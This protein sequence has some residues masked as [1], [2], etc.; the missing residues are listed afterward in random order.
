MSARLLE[1]S[2][3]SPSLGPAVVALGV[4][5]G[6]H[7][8]HAALVRDAVSIA[9]VEGIASVV[10]TFDRDPDRVVDPD[11]AAPQLLELDD[12]FDE[13]A[14]L[15]PDTVLVVPFD[16]GIAVMTPDAFLSDVLSRALDPVTVVV[17]HDFRFGRGASGDVAAL[18]RFGARAGFTVIAHRLVEAEGLPVS[19]TRIRGLVAAGDV[20]AAARL[21]GRPHRV[22]GTVVHGRG[23]GTAVAVPTANISVPSYAAL[24]CPGVFAG[25]V[26][27]AGETYPSA[28]AVG[29]PPT[30]PLANDVLEAHLIGFDGDIY[31]RAVTVEFLERLRDL[32]RF[33]DAVELTTAIRDDISAVRRRVL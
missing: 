31:G 15:S 10:V 25:R 18:E 1:W 23:A 29:T 9:G 13:L 19:S 22:R 27:L 24:P 16:E 11:R 33:E 20:T 8:G 12:K 32:R 2:P 30:F 21:M 3:A 7:I 6:V 28:I 5:D 14:A 4:F 26:R 17:G